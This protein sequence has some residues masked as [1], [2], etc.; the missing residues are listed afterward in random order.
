MVLFVKLLGIVIVVLGVVFLRKPAV[1]QKYI[2]FWKDEKR[3]KSGGIIAILLGIIFLIVDAQC[4]LSWLITI[5]GIWSIV[6]GVLLLTLSKKKVSACL[7][8]WVNKPVSVMRSIGIAAVVFG[9]LLIYA[10]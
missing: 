3:I 8:W 10:A 1:L 6:K 2:Q 5:F 7:D 9:L 4:R